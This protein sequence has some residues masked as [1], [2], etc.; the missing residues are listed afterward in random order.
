MAKCMGC[1][2]MS[3][4]MFKTVSFLAISLD[5]CLDTIKDSNVSIT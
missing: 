1:I 2:T 5:N 4:L 3:Y